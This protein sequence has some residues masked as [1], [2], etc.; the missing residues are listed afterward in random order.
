MPFGNTEIKHPAL[1]KWKVLSGCTLASEG[2]SAPWAASDLA[3]NHVPVTATSSSSASGDEEGKARAER[4]ADSADILSW[5]HGCCWDHGSW[6]QSPWVLVTWSLYFGGN[7]PGLG[8]QILVYKPCI[9]DTLV[10]PTLVLT[11]AHI[12]I[13]SIF[14]KEFS[15][16]MAT[17]TLYINLLTKSHLPLPCEFSSIKYKF[18]RLALRRTGGIIKAE[19]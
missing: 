4:G 11:W 2:H 12:C 15:W 7:T 10:D 1:C 8:V 18:G 14:P 5:W 9:H 19:M 17:T 3:L 13:S 6:E 16:Y